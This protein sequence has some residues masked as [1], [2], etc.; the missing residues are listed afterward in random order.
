[1]LSRSLRSFSTQRSGSFIGSALY[2]KDP[3]HGFSIVVNSQP[4]NAAYNQLK[5]CTREANLRG[6]ERRA[7]HNVKP[8]EKRRLIREQLKKNQKSRDFKE[9]VG[10]AAEIM[11]RSEASV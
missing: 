11:K 10:V 1:M 8:K 4:I 3:N 2:Q 9:L 6:L 5:E 7:Q